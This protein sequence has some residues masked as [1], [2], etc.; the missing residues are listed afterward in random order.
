MERYPMLDLVVRHG[1]AGAYVLALALAGI[2][3]LWLHHVPWWV[4][5]PT[6]AF[7]GAL[8]FFV[9]RCAVELVVLVTDMLVPR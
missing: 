8:A 6:A 1:A 3:L 2:V 4:V 9:A 5:A 7:V